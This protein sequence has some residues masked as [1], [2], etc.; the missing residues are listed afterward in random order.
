MDIDALQAD[1][2]PGGQGALADALFHMLRP[3]RLS[4]VVDIGANS[5]HND[6]PYK[7]ML[8]LG[9]C[10]VT[11]FE[12]QQIPLSELN[13]SKGPRERYFPYA[14]GNGEEATFHVCRAREM[15]SLLAPDPAHLALFNE[16]PKMGAIDGETRISTRRLD[17]VAEIEDIDFLKIDVQGA[18]L[19]VFKSGRKKLANTVAIQTEVSFVSL[20]RDQ[21]TI[22]AV[23]STLRE[24]GFIPHCF[25]ELKRWSIAP[26]VFGNT[27]I[28]GNQLLEADLV[29]VRDFSRPE[30]L[31][32]EQWKH[33]ALIAHHCYGSFDLA[34]RA[35][36]WAERLGALLNDV[37][38]RYINLL[39]KLS[40]TARGR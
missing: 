39:L 38:E 11:G 19:E 37:P 35:I 6:P 14:V 2:L 3:D 34:L 31:S 8:K 16:F 32:A 13:R 5:M 26:L 10:N 21:P 28:P 4:A 30:N 27:R 24:M 25:A 22:G 40:P 7:R 12:P 36:I 33:L 18:E 29:Y 17:D 20:Y 1:D 23:D 15:S 9:L